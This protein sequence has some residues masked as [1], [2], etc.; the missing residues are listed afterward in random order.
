M[1][2]V[3]VRTTAVKIR[4]MLYKYFNTPPTARTSGSS[5][6]EW[7]AVRRRIGWRG[8]LRIMR[9]KKLENNTSFYLVVLA[10]YI[11]VLHVFTTLGTQLSTCARRHGN[12]LIVSLCFN[13]FP[14]SLMYMYNIS[15]VKTRKACLPSK[16]DG[17]DKETV[18]DVGRT[19]RDWQREPATRCVHHWILRSQGTRYWLG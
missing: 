14:R 4:I 1:N 3:N 11:Y 19:L 13:C 8:P 18:S 2:G 17:S 6:S 5:R 7:E 15:L 12:V 10:L 9:F 16:Q